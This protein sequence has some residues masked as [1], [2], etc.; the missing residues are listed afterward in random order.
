M[1]LLTV[2]PAAIQKDTTP[3]TDKTVALNSSGHGDCERER[4]DF[5]AFEAKKEQ[6]LCLDLD[7]G[8]L[9]GGGEV[10]CG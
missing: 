9:M 4:R 6:R 2:V 8:G 7:C 5:Y 3:E 10:I 1:G